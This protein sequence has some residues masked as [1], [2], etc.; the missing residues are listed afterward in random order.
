[1]QTS[2][3][4]CHLA[5]ADDRGVGWVGGRLGAA[6]GPESY[7]LRLQELIRSTALARPQVQAGGDPTPGPWVEAAQVEHEQVAH[8]FAQLAREHTS[9]I[10]VGG[11]NDHAYSQVLGL[12]ELHPGR[13]AC[14]NIDAHL[15][16]RPYDVAR[17]N[18]GSPFRRLLDEHVISS[19]QM[20][21][22]G[23]QPLSNH[24]DLRAYA[25]RT[26]L[27]VIEFA[28]ARRVGVAKS[29]AA[30]LKRLGR[31]ADR[32]AI[33]LDL[34]AVQ[35]ADAPGVSAPA[36]EGFSAA[37]CLELMRISGRDP[38]VATLGIFELNPLHDEG[39]RTARLAA[40]STLNFLIER[41]R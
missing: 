26:G 17:M 13:V 14:I 31:V 21:E 16:V 22:F 30:A 18:S 32:I 15:D 28:E 41:E 35:G 38:R 33:C 36:T 3:K 37:E 34:D 6:L 20:V 23:I 1:M 11:G 19:R 12:A 40:R 27:D 8:S 9:V 24:P 7:R 10:V 29:F 25:E 2:S 4:W 5:V 39:L